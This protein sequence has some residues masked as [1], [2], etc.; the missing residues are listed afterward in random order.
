MITS[1]IKLQ[2]RPD[3]VRPFKITN[4]TSY[5]A[6]DKLGISMDEG[7]NPL[8]TP[9]VT[10]PVQ[11]LQHFLPGTIEMVTSAR[12]ADELMGRDIVADWSAAEVVTTVTEQL[13]SARPYGDDVST[14][15]ANYN[16]NYERRSIARFEQGIQV[17]ALEQE[18][19]N[20]MRISA[21]GLKRAAAGRALAITL[22]NVAFY[23]YNDGAHR[24][25]GFFNDPNL[26]AYATVATGAGGN[27]TWAS[28]TFNEICADIRTAISG[29]RV[30]S[31]DLFDPYNDAFSIAVSL[32][33]VELLTKITDLGVSVRDWISKTYPKAVIKSAP[34]L[35]GANGGANIFYVYADEIE[36]TKVFAQHVVTVFRVMG[37]QK[38]AK[39][40]I[41]AYSNATAGAILNCPIGLVRYT[42]I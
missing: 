14:P 32:S 16:V 15:L 1:E 28:K 40:Y 39:G 33:C 22:N 9:T 21:D 23:G 20:K 7:I 26:P 31:G 4:N 13:G 6:L 30:K 19:A 10:T 29:L 2:M 25:Y 42:G 35:D 34:E 12:K 5:N 8:T 3:Q 37:I 11:F 27:T 41:E 36:G 38:T 17:S 24:T 18:R